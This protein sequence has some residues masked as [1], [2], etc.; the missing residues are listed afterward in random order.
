MKIH[1]FEMWLK[2]IKQLVFGNYAEKLCQFRIS[3]NAREGYKE[4]LF[5]ECG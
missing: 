1:V 2:F 3:V 5:W 4:L